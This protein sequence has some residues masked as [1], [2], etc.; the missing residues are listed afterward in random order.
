V[1]GCCELQDAPRT[2]NQ[3]NTRQRKVAW[4]PSTR[5]QHRRRNAVPFG[6]QW[7]VSGGRNVQRHSCENTFG[8][9]KRETAPTARRRRPTSHL[10]LGPGA[11]TAMAR[12]QPASRPPIH[13]DATSMAVQPSVRTVVNRVN[14]EDSLALSPASTLDPPT[15]PH[16][17]G[18]RVGT[19][20]AG[21]SDGVPAPLPPPHHLR[22]QWV[23]VIGG[24]C[25]PSRHRDRCVWSAALY[26]VGHWQAVAARD[27]TLSTA[28]PTEL[29]VCCLDVGLPF[30]V[31]P[32]GWH[33]WAG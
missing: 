14:S 26:S 32:A 29:Q 12:V 27:N 16:M 28:N 22:L 18:V 2:M 9:W 10:H 25:R 33:D 31:L 4:V 17:R 1:A 19:V 30:Y 15:P 6:L 7:H 8:C 24:H 5:A 11:S 21:A 13:P 20:E 3:A 23:V